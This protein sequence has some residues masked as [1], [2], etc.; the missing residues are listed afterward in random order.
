MLFIIFSTILPL[1]Y[2]GKLVLNCKKSIFGT[3]SITM[4]WVIVYRVELQKKNINLCHN[5]NIKDHTAKD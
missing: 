2:N 5:G 1:N 4:F 3:I